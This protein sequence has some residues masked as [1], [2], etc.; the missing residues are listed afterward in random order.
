M[1]SF[2]DNELK[3]ILKAHVLWLKGS[4]QGKRA[5]LRGVD[6]RGVNLMGANLIE[7]DL[8]GAN[9]SGA[10]LTSAYLTNANL[11]GA[12]LEGAN[13]IES[14]LRGANLEGANLSD[15]DLSYAD[16][17]GAY[18]SGAD[19]SGRSVIHLDK[20]REYT[21]YVIPEVRNG[22]IFVAGCRNFTYKEAVKHWT[23]T[24]PAYVEAIEAW[25]GK[26]IK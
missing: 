2:T 16:L 11:E 9:L 1:N 6:L 15:A 8:R 17:S 19:L 24:Q 7:S 12:H 18:L 5:N 10:D 22:P 4:T 26:A 25:A 13:L 21:L 23:K 14:D 3:D 20:D